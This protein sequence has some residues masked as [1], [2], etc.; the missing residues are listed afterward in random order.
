MQFQRLTAAISGVR[1]DRRC[2]SDDVAPISYNAIVDNYEPFSRAEPSR[3]RTIRCN[4]V[5]DGQRRRLMP[6]SQSVNHIDCLAPTSKVT[7]Q[8]CDDSQTEAGSRFRK[9]LDAIR[10]NLISRV[11]RKR[12]DVV[13]RANDDG[14]G[15]HQKHEVSAVC[16][17]ELSAVHQSET[18]CNSAVRSSVEASSSPLFE[19]RRIQRRTPRRHRTV[20]DGE[21]VEAARGML[22]RNVSSAS[23]MSSSREMQQPKVDDVVEHQLSRFTGDTH[24]RD[25]STAA[26]DVTSVSTDT[27]NH[28]DIQQLQF[29]R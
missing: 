11:T 25:V 10:G 26:S 5:S 7:F 18:I 15:N 24:Q 23:D 2:Q 1:R 27:V 22:H 14:A 3:S 9:R 8:V 20:V 17:S 13:G 29:T 4:S 6:R 12:S 19:R 16:Q 21:Q 28:N